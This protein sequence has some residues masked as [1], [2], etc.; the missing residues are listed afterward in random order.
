MVLCGAN[1][2][3][4]LRKIVGNV[5]LNYQELYYIKFEA[6]SK[7]LKSKKGSF[8]PRPGSPSAQTHHRFQRLEQG[9]WDHLRRFRPRILLHQNRTPQQPAALRGAPL[10]HKL[11]S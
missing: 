6:T 3:A 9:Q 7:V 11:I 1:A 10:L 8:T 2:F 5:L 4:K